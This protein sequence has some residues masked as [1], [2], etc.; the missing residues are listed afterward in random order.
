MATKEAPIENLVLNTKLVEDIMRREN[1]GQKLK[2][3]EKLWFTNM[4][5]VRKANIAFGM[6]DDEVQEYFK[7]KM[8]CHYFAQKYCQIKRE[9]GTIGP[10]ILRDYQKDIIDLYTQNRFSI[11][12]ASRQTGKAQDLDSIVWD[13]NGKKRFGDLQIGDKIYDDNGELTTIIGIYPQGE[14]DIYEVEFSD[15]LKVRCCNEHLWEVEKNGKIKVVELSDIMKNYLTK[16]GDS[17]YYVKVAQPVNYPEKELPISPYLLGLIIG[18][19]STRNNRLNISTKDQQIIDYL[20]ELEDDDIYIKKL[21]ET[22]DYAITK[23][24]KTKRHKIIQEL[25]KLDLMEKLSYDKFIPKMYLYSSINQ[26]LELLRGLMDTDGFICK[27]QP[28]YSTSSKQLS[29]DFRELCHSLGIRTN[30][31]EKETTYTYKGKKKKGYKSYIVRLL[32][33]NDYP[34]PIFKLDRKQSQIKN[35]RFDWGQKRGIVNIKYIG[36]KEAQCIEVN[37]ESHLYLTDNYIPTHNTV[38]AAIVILWYCLFSNDK[39]VMIVANKG[40]TVVEIIRKIKEIYKLLPFFLKKGILN[41]NEKSIAFEN[42]CRIQTENRTKEPSIGFTI[43][44]LYL[45]EFAKVPANIIEAYY[46][47]VVPTVSSINNSKIVITS[48]PEGFN[49]FH[50]LLTDAERDIDDPL[51]NMYNPMRVYWHQ[52]KGRMDVKIFPLGYKLKEYKISREDIE[53]QLVKLGYTL[54]H[55]N[56]DNRD[57]IYLSYDPDDEKTTLNSIRCIRLELNE[58]LIPL[59]EI[60]VITSWKEEETKLIGGEQMFNQEYDLQFVTGDK[61]LFDSDTMNK[62]KHDSIDFGYVQ[63]AKLDNALTLPY[64]QMKWIKNRSDLFNPEKMKEYYICASIDLGEGLGQDYSV[65][66]IFRLMPKS[67]ELIEKTY[68]TLT[69]VYEYFYLEQIGMIRVNNWSISEF[70][71]LF[72]MV[73]FELFDPEKSKVVLEYN[74][75]GATLL[76]EMTKI[77][78]GEH[79]YSSGIFLR[80]KHRKEDTQLKIGIKITGGEHE[81]AKKIL[82]KELQGAVKK[83]LIKLHN[84]ININEITLFTKRETPSGNFTYQ[85]ESGHDDCLL[86]DTWIKTINGYKKI[87]DI[88]IGELVLTHLG[89]YKPVTNICIKEFDGDMYDIKF[90]GQPNLNITYNHPIYTHTYSKN[91]RIFNTKKWVLPSEINKNYKSITLFEKY[92]KNENE[93]IPFE[94]IFERHKL[95]SENNIKLKNI[96]LDKNF[97]KFLG[98]FLADGNCYKPTKTSYRVSVSFNK[99]DTELISDIKIYLQSLGLNVFENLKNNCLTLIVNNKTLY[100]FLIHCYDIESREKILP[101]YA[102][103]LGSDLFFVL[104]YWLKGDGWTRKG[105]NNRLDSVIGC[106]TSLQL[107]LSMRDIAIS[108]NKYSLINKNKRYRYGKKNKDQYWV[109]IYDNFPKISSL[110]KISN[111]E[112]SSNLDYIEKYEYNGITYNLEVKDDNS[113]I[114]NGIVVHNCVMSLVTLSSTFS[115]VQYKNLIEHMMD[116]YLQKEHKDYIEK[117]AYNKKT[118]EKVNYDATKT[119]YNKVYKSNFNNQNFRPF[120]SSPWSK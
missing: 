107:A 3:H 8:S 115:H 110:K 31:R 79:N 65:L 62:F 18:D 42:G 109:T 34:Y 104:E 27:N 59:S 12:M 13:S 112:I 51:K 44:F 21:Y 80:Y 89:N 19:G 75:Y 102:N 113:Y 4:K 98:L 26:R 14:K 49:L 99:K 70:A 71:E 35:K 58:Q 56:E 69:N 103:K 1:L 37:N 85:C 68:S 9:D 114:A 108:S 45:D 30:I 76:S 101:Y 86:P 2:K 95:N 92:D 39:G 40:K 15:G 74:T 41:W 33:K 16:R 106:T 57:W 60:C 81:A 32:L 88:E 93:I 22:C 20:Y 83:S 116:N 53:E 97:A 46:G 29:E 36:K 25:N 17:I 55:K 82:V 23:K 91:K 78:Q 119:T 52:V 118:D 47:A 28:S 67:K 43:D 105:K 96:K 66:N 54:T 5:G 72:Y 111:F 87:K 48:T 94:K 10:M 117:C 50:K 64:N 38:S 100:E 73:M 90:K 120:K 61:L 84:D 24:D 63:F 77:F 7:C 11:L 6:T